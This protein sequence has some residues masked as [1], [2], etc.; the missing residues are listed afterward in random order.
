MQKK[1]R[2]QQKLESK[3]EERD[4]RWLEERVEEVDRELE[5]CYDKTQT[6]AY[7]IER[8]KT[9][10]EPLEFNINKK[11]GMSACEVNIWL[12]DQ[13]MQPYGSAETCKLGML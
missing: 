10:L 1:L 3:R 11:E 7:E 9:V 8:I 2:L 6:H 12:L 13:L 4:K 5:D